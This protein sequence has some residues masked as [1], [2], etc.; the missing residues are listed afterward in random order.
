ME[1]DDLPDELLLQIFFRLSLGSLNDIYGLTLTCKKWRR[2]LWSKEFFQR[3]NSFKYQSRFLI[4]H[5]SPSNSVD[6]NSLHAFLEYDSHSTIPYLAINGG[7]SNLKQGIKNF[8]LINIRGAQVWNFSSTSR[9]VSRLT[10][11]NPAHIS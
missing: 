9:D 6:E 5:F 8:P 3:I 1:L 2:I 10:P 7:L 11:F 4:Y